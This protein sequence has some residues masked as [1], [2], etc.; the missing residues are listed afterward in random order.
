MFLILQT[1]QGACIVAYE[2][3]FIV[4]GGLAKKSEVLQF[5]HTTKVRKPGSKL[6]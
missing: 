5:N 1:F 2:D 4:M 6:L 3:S